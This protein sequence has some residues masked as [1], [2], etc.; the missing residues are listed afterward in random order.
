[1]RRTR[2][3]R[4]DGRSN[5][6]WGRGS[7]GENRSNALWGR[8]GRRAGAAV[9]VL[10]T[11]LA[12]AASATAGGGRGHEFW[13]YNV[14]GMG[15]V[16][17]YIPDSL[18]S[19]IQQNARQKFDVIVE[20]VQTP[21]SSSQKRVNARG[22]RTGL[23]GAQ[24]GA[25][26]IGGPQI[27]RL[28]SAIDGLHASLTG[29]QISVPRQASVRR[30]DHAER[31]RA[32]EL[33]RRPAVLE[34]PEVGLDGRR[35][36]DWSSW[37]ASLSQPTIAIVDSG[38]DTSSGA[39]GNRVLGQVNL[40]SLTPNSPGD[41]D[42]HG[43]FV[44]AMAAG[45]A[46][47]YAGVTPTANLLSLDVMNDQGEATVSDVIAACDWILQNK[48]TY[49]IRVAN[50]SLHAANRASLFFDPLDQ[51]V[52]KLWLN[53]VTVVA[54]AGNY[55]QDGQ[56]SGVPFAP[57]NDPFVITVGAADISNTVPTSDDT[58]A[59]WSAWGYTPDGFMKPDI[60]AP[61]RYLIGPVSK[62]G[63]LALGRPD[64]VVAPGYMQLSGTSFSAPMV[65]G[66]AAML[67]A[68]HPGWTP[69]QVK[70]ALMVSA[71]GTPS[72]A[73]GSLGVGEL[74][75]SAARWVSNPPNPNAALDGF[76]TTAPDGTVSFDSAAWQAA[77][78]SDAAWA[79]RSLERRRLGLR[80]LERRRLGLR[81]LGRRR[82]ER[83][84][85]ERRSLGG[86]SL[87]GRG[88]RR[89]SRPARHHGGH[90]GRDLCRRYFARHRSDRRP[91]EHAVALEPRT[92]CFDGPRTSG[93]R[94]AWKNP[95]FRASGMLRTGDAPG[96]GGS[97]SPAMA[98]RPSDPTRAGHHAVPT[99]LATSP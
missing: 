62:G 77:A 20:G 95:V 41:G 44:A 4:S 23:L 6:L 29:R 13:G 81:S 63:G 39:F 40:T 38:I 15:R 12:L 57:G 8:G 75:M 16:S 66:A 25:D 35:P 82:L 24:Q 11:A 45:A 49:N 32:D 54:A 73:P 69:D 46:A 56:E 74:D 42:G 28:F 90:A 64:H 43:T 18:A 93:A 33:V 1:M 80:S 51:A 53:G 17:A 72:A 5:A 67:L 79:C 7:R 98:L 78:L 47:G 26:T 61:G 84:R 87:G 10:A 36:L 58:A 52:E 59:P 83:R 68:Q 91:R 65:S 86:R 76:L 19:A 2:L 22:L 71:S 96:P 37:S 55:A 85:V 48:Q 21:Q 60:S 97:Y 27:D 14:Q 88:L 92:A 9:A 99:P 89:S 94:S 50:F 70:G 30:G 31:D 34:Q 3:D